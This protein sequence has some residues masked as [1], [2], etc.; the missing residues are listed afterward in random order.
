LHP[1]F[2]QR[3][4]LMSLTAKRGAKNLQTVRKLPI[5]PK[6]VAQNSVFDDFSGS[7]RSEAAKARPDFRVRDR[8]AEISHGLLDFC[9]S[10]L[11]LRAVF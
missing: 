11:T 2:A 3:K 4:P 8:L 1:F 7:D 10:K 9:T 6:N 5:R